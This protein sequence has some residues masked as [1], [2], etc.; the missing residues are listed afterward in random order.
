MAILFGQLRK[1]SHFA[2]LLLVY[3][4]A[5]RAFM[6]RHNL[7]TIVAFALVTCI[8]I[9]CGPD[10]SLGRRPVSGQVTL[11]GAPIESG[12]IDFQPLQSGG[13]SSGGLITNGTYEISE[14]QGLPVGKY[15]V[16]IVAAAP[17]PTSLPAGYMPGDEL[18][19]APPQKQKVPS[20]W[21]EKGETIE[22]KP[23]GPNKFD[24]AIESAKE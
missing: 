16:T 3:S 21:N 22:V 12:S 2:F 23:E 15:R 1:S 6:T 24:F 18:P 5:H 17:Q 9:G 13:T 10:N 4:I 19:A 7:S 8:S 20:A 11:D 14:E